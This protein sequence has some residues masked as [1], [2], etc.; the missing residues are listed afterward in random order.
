MLNG[1]KFIDRA[2]PIADKFYILTRDDAS[3]SAAS[4]KPSKQEQK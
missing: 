2:S 3:V 4:L 1:E